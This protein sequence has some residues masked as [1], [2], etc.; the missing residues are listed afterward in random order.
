MLVFFA[1]QTLLV[2]SLGDG[3]HAK[4]AAEKQMPLMVAM[5]LVSKLAS[6]DTSMIRNTIPSP[7]GTLNS[8]PQ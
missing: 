1:L 8:V 4:N 3:K 6:A 5:G 7:I 2:Q